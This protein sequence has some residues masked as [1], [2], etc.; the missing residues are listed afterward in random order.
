M[1]RPSLLLC[2][3][4]AAPAAAQTLTPAQVRGIDSV[5]A[6][7]DGT[8][9]PGCSVGVSH[10]G[11]RYLHGYGMSDLQQGTAITP[12]SIFHVA[13]VSKQF[14]AFAVGLLADDGALSLDDPIR[15]YVPEVP[16][17]GTPLSLRRLMH[18]T[19]GLRDQWELLG[20]A[21][22]RYPDDLFT[23][24]DVL[25]IIS[26]QRDLN[27]KPGDEWLYSNT[28]YT[29]LAVVVERVSGMSLRAF[30]DTRV[31]QPLGMTR[32]HVHD[33]HAMIVRGRTSA[34]QWAAGGWKISVP[35]FDTHGATSLFTTPE[36][37][38]KW[39]ANFESG[40]VGSAG[41]RAEAVRSAILNDGR[42]AN[43][44]FG[45]SLDE[46]RGTPALG[47]GG[48][49]AGYRAQVVRYPEHRLAVAVACNFAEAGPGGLANA[50][51][52]VVVGDRLAARPVPPEPVVGDPAEL[53]R[54][55]GVYRSLGSDA[56][57]RLVVRGRRL[58]VDGVGVALTSTA[59][60]RFEGSGLTFEFGGD[61]GT[62]P[63]GGR[64]LRS[65]APADSVIRAEPFAPAPGA[66]AE[67]AGAYWSDEVGAPMTVVAADSVLRVVPSKFQGDDLR[68]LPLYR[69]AFALGSS[70][71]RFVREKGRVTGFR[72]SGGRV[73]NVLFTKGKTRP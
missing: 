22:W 19:S 45:I 30:L 63:A 10:A 49:D 72:Y 47:H 3:L 50:V 57:Y 55:A 69:D 2:W 58:V 73:R 23:Q 1:T 42:P 68:F 67:Y 32:T 43:Y 31:F 40:R 36:D 54:F 5:F 66:L 24:G 46:F 15:Q 25:A 26:R 70:V 16:D 56:G 7:L 12:E 37:L 8:D 39:E 28:G 13:S 48:A 11:A 18:H 65:R 41:L 35:Q 6:R 59:P 14:T 61:A 44:G 51:A 60:R 9:R 27:F 4:A 34:Y 53:G 71:L 62:V 20:L 29:L 38:L 33:D 64:V 52:E 17:Y 21:G